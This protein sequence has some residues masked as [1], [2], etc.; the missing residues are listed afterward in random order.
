M[1]KETNT[2]NM[3]TDMPAHS[4]RDQQIG[5]RQKEFGNSIMNLISYTGFTLDD[6]TQANFG[7]C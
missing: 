7:T 3:H 5:E 6:L 1:K 2:I 4:Q